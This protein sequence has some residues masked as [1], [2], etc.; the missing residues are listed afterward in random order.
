VPKP[1]YIELARDIR[2]PILYEDRAVMAID[3]PPGWMLVPISWQRTSWNLQAAIMSSMA[4]GHFWARSRNLKFLKY[5]HRLDAETSGILLL[6]KSQGALNTYSDL[7]ESR[8][9]EK[10]YLAVTAREPKQ[11]QWNCRL[12]IAP[13]LKEHGRMIVSADGKPAETEFRVLASNDGKHLIEARPYSGRQHQIRLHLAESG[14]PIVGDELYGGG[15]GDMAL[16]AVGLAYQD[17]FTR[18]TI[19]IRAS[20]EPFMEQFGVAAANYRVEF[21]T[22]GPVRPPKPELPKPSGENQSRK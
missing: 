6:A 2:I 10:V 12:S 7:F 1:N 3:K 13:H 15:E 8:R 4:A 11:A 16:R 17:P 5:I 19:F 18:K 20:V 14:C 21:T 9:M 22:S